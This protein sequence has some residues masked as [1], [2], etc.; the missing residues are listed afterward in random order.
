MMPGADPFEEL[1]AALA[2][3][4]GTSVGGLAELM[5]ADRRGIGRAVK[6]ILP[7]ETSELVLV[8][9]QFEEIFTLCPDAAVRHRFAAG[10]VAAISE[11]RSRL[12]VVST[13]RADFYDRP[14][15]VPE[16]AAVVEQG[17]VVLAPLAADELELAITE[18]ALRAGSRF[19]PGLVARIV[20]DVVDQPGA[21]P[22]LQYALTELFERR[23]AE[24]DDHGRL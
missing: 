16:L 17:T 24:R 14:L 11:V 2:R 13:L 5:A 3:V 18:P 20:A 4:A 15:R 9:D 6:Q 12:R 8:I 10:L 23:E 21:L 1:E 22:L 7:D 19:E